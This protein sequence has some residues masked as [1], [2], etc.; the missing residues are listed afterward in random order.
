MLRVME[1]HVP[2]EGVPKQEGGGPSMGGVCAH[3]R[4]CMEQAQDGTYS[5]RRL[6][7][8]S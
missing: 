5:S 4:A 7:L 1:G 6:W 3:R 2:R 8:S